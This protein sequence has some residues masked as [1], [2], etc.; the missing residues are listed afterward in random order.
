MLSASFFA[1]YRKPEAWTSMRECFFARLPVFKV[2]SSSRSEATA[3]FSLPSA[4][5]LLLLCED[6]GFSR[7]SWVG[8]T[9][10]HEKIWPTEPAWLSQLF[11]L[12]MNT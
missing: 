3:M 4:R 9:P 6:F 10:N 11:G 1:G 8:T 2:L 12:E 5:F 7:R